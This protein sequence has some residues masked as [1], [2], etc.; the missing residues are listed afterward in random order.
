MD[1]ISYSEA[2]S[3]TM[4]S[5][6]WVTMQAAQFL[7]PGSGRNLSYGELDQNPFNLP[8]DLTIWDAY[9]AD[10]SCPDMERIG[11]IGDGR[12]SCALN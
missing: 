7:A 10:I 6:K 4:V 11:R 3:P 5:Q 1:P 9:F 2:E 8:R 12:K